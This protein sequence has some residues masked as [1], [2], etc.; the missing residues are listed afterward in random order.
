VRR[1]ANN[2]GVTT[3]APSEQRPRWERLVGSIRHL[4]D[5][6]FA[7]AYEQIKAEAARRRRSS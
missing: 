3:L 1:Y 5:D 6:D 2:G 7:R 4:D